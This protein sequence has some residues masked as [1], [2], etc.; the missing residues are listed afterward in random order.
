MNASARRE[1]YRKEL[2]A[3]ILDAAREIFSRD[4]Y[5]AFT[6]RKL[7]KSMEYSPAN[8]YLYFKDK[9]EIFDRLV[10]ESFARLLEALPQ[11]S[12]VY[13]EDPVSL[14]KRSLHTYVNFGLS[15]PNHY[16][17]AFLL[18]PEGQARPHKQRAAY[19]SLLLKVSLCIEKKRFRT[20]DVN[21]ASQALWAAA[22]GITSLLIHRPLFPW[23]ERNR[24]IRRVIDSAVDSLL[25]GSLGR[26]AKGKTK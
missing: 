18:R 25:V 9:N 26:T 14:L 7:A 24:L 6:M 5:E 4:G 1:K 19:E 22:H 13:P 20:V 10:E 16:Q 12:G 8:I 3:E 21:L 11:P 17:F 23:V 2:R 15:H